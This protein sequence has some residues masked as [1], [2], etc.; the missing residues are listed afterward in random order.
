MIHQPFFLFLFV[1]AL[2]QFERK[3][4]YI[5]SRNVWLIA[6]FFA[7]YL[8][9]AEL[10]SSIQMSLQDHHWGY[11]LNWDLPALIFQGLFGLWIVYRIWS[12]RQP[13]KQQ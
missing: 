3:Q 4:E 7:L 2:I 11:L 10:Y 12:T 5:K 6:G 13:K 8:T 1:L 9:G